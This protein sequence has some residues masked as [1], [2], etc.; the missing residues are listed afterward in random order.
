MKENEAPEI[1]ILH[2]WA[3]D[4]ENEKKWEAVRTFLQEKN[5]KTVFLPLP[6]L[7][8]SLPDENKAWNLSDYVTWLDGQ[9]PDQP[10]I[11]LGHSFG[12]QLAV[13]F[14]TLYPMRVA[15]LVLIASSGIRDKSSKAQ[16]KRAIFYGLAKAGKVFSLIPGAR[17]IL[18]ALAGER[19]YYKAP[20]IMRKT[21]ANVISE[22]I[23]ADL[24]QITAESLVLWGTSDTITPPKNIEYFRQIPKVTVQLIEGARHSPQFTHPEVVAKEIAAFLIKV[25]AK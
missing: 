7:T 1:Y 11:L 8:V 2:G 6:G 25:A 17:N 3:V 4:K 18:Y 19:D 21:M 5:I 24:P 20:E 16:V 15:R 12:G 22:E 9:L 10:V 13:R 23:I 14:V